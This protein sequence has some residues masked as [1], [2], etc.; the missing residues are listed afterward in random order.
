MIPSLR[1]AVLR[2]TAAVSVIVATAS[3]I[4]RLSGQEAPGPAPVSAPARPS[5]P[6]VKQAP[7]GSEACGPCS[8]YNALQAGTAD[9]RA[10]LAAL[11]AG[12]PEDRVRH[13]IT[14]HGTK[15]AVVHRGRFPRYTADGGMPADEMPLF[16]QDVLG[17]AGAPAGRTVV[18]TW[19]ERAADE[20]QDKHLRRVHA[21]L[22]RHLD[23]GL[24]PIIDVQSYAARPT[25]WRF[26]WDRLAGHFVVVV[27][28]QPVI[29]DGDKQFWFRYAD[30]LTG[31]VERAFA[32]L[33]EAR[34]Y[35]ATRHFTPNP[36]GSL[37][38]TWLEGFPYLVVSAP[39]LRMG[40]DREPFQS[41][42][43]IVLRH[44]T[45]VAPPAAD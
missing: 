21:T 45:G 20:P 41:R 22:K 40:T 11:P 3:G 7:I 38:W 14:T 23:A 44:V 43:I 28:V 27:E 9:F 2:V 5:A 37:K 6:V 4:G 18:A 36:D 16:L 42:T 30:S 31:R 24:P 1:P 35:S 15:P 34:P 8:V 25:G 17:G 29:E 33:E 10:V 19:L 12:T 39:S 32:S 26:L 13:L